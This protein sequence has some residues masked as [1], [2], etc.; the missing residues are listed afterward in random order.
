MTT[1]SDQAIEALKHATE[2]VTIALH[3]MAESIE[4]GPDMAFVAAG[5]IKVTELLAVIQRL[6]KVNEAI[7]LKMDTLT[8][9]QFRQL[10][11]QPTVAPDQRNT[12][13]DNNDQG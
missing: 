3:R 1:D 8:D 5:N 6:T 12:G 10:L 9:A 4:S 13:R 2:G 11:E 7:L